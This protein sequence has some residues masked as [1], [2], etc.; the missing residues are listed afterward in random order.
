ME[1]RASFSQLAYQLRWQAEN[2]RKDHANER[3]PLQTL[4]KYPQ[5]NFICQPPYQDQE[6]KA[7]L[8]TC[9]AK[10]MQTTQRLSKQNVTSNIS[11]SET[12]ILKR[13]QE[14][15]FCYL[16]SDKGSECVVVFEVWWK[17]LNT[18][19]RH[20]NIWETPPLTTHDPEDRRG[21]NQ[22]NMEV[23]LHRIQHRSFHNEKLC[24]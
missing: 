7:K 17:T 2:A 13:L 15:D 22:P 19:M 6:L 3:M 18:M 23:C 4:L 5:S 11:C 16:P 8:R 9:Y 24:E 14:K 20:S 12:Q 21:Q 10:I 1:I